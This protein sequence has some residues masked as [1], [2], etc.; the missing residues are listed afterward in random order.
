MML[1]AGCTL[2]PRLLLKFTFKHCVI[3][4]LVTRTIS[5]THVIPCDLSSTEWRRV[6]VTAMNDTVSSNH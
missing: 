4:E 3:H 5:I 1:L 2:I 6:T